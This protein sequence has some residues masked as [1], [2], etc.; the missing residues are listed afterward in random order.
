MGYD[1][2][3]SS[4]SSNSAGA[5]NK[6]SDLMKTIGLILAL[7]MALP[8]SV[9]A[10]DYTADG[11]VTNPGYDGPALNPMVVALGGT[12]VFAIQMIAGPLAPALVS[13][14]FI[15]W[16]ANRTNFWRGSDYDMDK[17]GVDH[18]EIQAG[19]V[20]ELLG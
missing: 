1:F 7:V 11:R 6:G 3:G 19:T 14:G 5:N 17:G 8:M 9:S 13:L 16:G 20:G 2:Y 10:A 18:Y 12:G 15:T 4:V